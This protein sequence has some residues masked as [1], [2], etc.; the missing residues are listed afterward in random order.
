MGERV[1]RRAGF[2]RTGTGQTWWMHPGPRPTP[3]QTRLVEA[4]G[5]G[6]LDAITGDL[7][8]EIPG[9]GTPLVVALDTGRADSAE[10][11]LTRVPDLL[12]RRMDERGATLLHLAVE[13]GDEP[14]VRM[15]LARGADTTIRDTEFNATPADWAKHF[16]RPE[17][18][19]LL[20]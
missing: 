9:A 10:L 1:Y 18:A 16:E 2:V 11:I 5:F 13:R 4:I 14:L 7:E 3:E 17:L 8:A 12:D 6:E 19:T 20:S 15:A